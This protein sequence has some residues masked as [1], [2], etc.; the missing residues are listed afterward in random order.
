M[1]SGAERLRVVNPGNATALNNL[2][3]LHLIAVQ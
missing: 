1:Y 2:V 3:V